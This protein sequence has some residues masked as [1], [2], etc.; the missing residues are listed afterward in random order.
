MIE[1]G[2]FGEYTNKSDSAWN[3]VERNVFEYAFGRYFKSKFNWL[4]NKENRTIPAIMT[5]FGRL[6]PDDFRVLDLGTGT[7]HIP[8]SLIDIGVKPENIVG[9]DNNFE[10]LIVENY[11]SDVHKLCTDVK[12][13]VPTLKKELPGF[14]NFDLVTANMVFHL[15]TFGDYIKTLKQVRKVVTDRAQ[16]YIMLPHP[17][18]DEM[19][20]IADYHR[21]GVISEKTPWGEYINYGT[22]TIA[23][24]CRGLKEAGFDCWVIG[25]TGVGLKLEDNLLLHDEAIWS[26]VQY[27]KKGYSTRPLPHYFR[28]WLMASPEKYFV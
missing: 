15:L 12:K 16:L 6:I 22:K 24:Y 18:R 7:G 4:N 5:K 13:F 8:E 1:A 9:V 25:T 17:L 26:N 20:S 21:H 3:L 10:M 27:R 19:D 11:P 28:L 23:D 2:K 14:G